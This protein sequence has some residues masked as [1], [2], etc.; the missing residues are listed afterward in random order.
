MTQVKNWAVNAEEA[1]SDAAHRYM[2]VKGYKAIMR[3]VVS[4]SCEE[5]RY[6]RRGN[7]YA[8]GSINY[9]INTET[10]DFSFFRI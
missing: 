6:Y 2:L 10:V 3:V 9:N 4:G 8:I 7:K 5:M 1:G